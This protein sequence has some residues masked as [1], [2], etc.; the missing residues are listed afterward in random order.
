MSYKQAGQS[1]KQISALLS[2]NFIYVLN[3]W[4]LSTLLHYTK[5]YLVKQMLI[6]MDVLDVNIK[7]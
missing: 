5:I 3:N 1:S 4:K 6:Y 2:T 7:C